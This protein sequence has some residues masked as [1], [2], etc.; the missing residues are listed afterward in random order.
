[1]KR[2]HPVAVL[3][4]LSCCLSLPTS[5]RAQAVPIP[6]LPTVNLNHVDN[7]T[8][9]L[10]TAGER[11]AADIA[12]WV[13]VGVALAL[14]ARAALKADDEGPLIA[15]A[16]RIGINVAVGLLVKHVSHRMRPDGS[17]DE[18]FYS[19]HTALAFSTLQGSG[20]RLVFTLPLAVS[21]GGLRVA[22]GKHFLTDVLAGAGVG[23]AT[24][25]FLR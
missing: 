18:S 10:P 3:A 2:C 14:D 8:P 23:L 1:M 25:H 24:G 21:S 6:Q 4:I 12:S 15:A 11:R 22:A 13:T 17:N 9:M 20:A 5:A 19:M 16:E 7:L